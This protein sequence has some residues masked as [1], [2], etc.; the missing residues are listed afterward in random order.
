MGLGWLGIYGRLS[1]LGSLFGGTLNNRCRSIIKDPKRDQ[2]FD[3]HPYSY[4]CFVVFR[5]Q[6]VVVEGSESPPRKV[7]NLLSP[8]AQHVGA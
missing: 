3:N 2:N 4:R 8:H 1:K 6:A 7:S 5:V